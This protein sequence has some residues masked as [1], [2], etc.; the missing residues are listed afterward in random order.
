MGVKKLKKA[1]IIF[2][3][4]LMI[5][6]LG[7]CSKEIMTS[8]PPQHKKTGDFEVKVGSEEQLEEKEKEQPKINE[9]IKKDV[10]PPLKSSLKELKY[11]I[12]KDKVYYT[13][14][15]VVLTYHHISTKPISSITIKP[16]RFEADLKMLKEN[17]FNVISLR[18]MINAVQ[19]Q[20]KLPPNSVVI[21]FDDGYESF[22]KY[23]YPLLMKYNMPG[24][25]FVITSWTENYTPTGKELNS[26]G[27][28]QIREMYKSGIIDIQSH[29]HDGHDY[30]VR[31]EKGQLGGRLAFRIYDK[32]SA[33][34]ELEDVYRK[35]VLEDLSKSIPLIE[36]YT[37][38]KPDIFCF[39]FGHYNSRLVELGK[40]AG[41][42]YFVTTVYGNN[43]ENSKSIM[44]RRI[45]SGDAKLSPEKLKNN[46]IV[47]G[48][49]KPVK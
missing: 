49:G 36:K 19:G 39:P 32:S 29:S 30:I 26:L 1:S 7:A 5:I 34:F 21:T 8:N 17:N 2:S 40:K 38:N 18:D 13:G 44:I 15:A 47:C 31:N 4:L 10:L 45:R 43:R 11:D 3:V 28:D 16:E 37:D 14:R 46:I 9:E 42:K 41:F 27:P 12:P 6:L 33:G 22:Y 20:D 48:Q 25:N 24:V 35:R 23:A